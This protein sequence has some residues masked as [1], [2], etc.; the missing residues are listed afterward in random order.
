M[1]RCP[2]HPTHPTSKSKRGSETERQTEL[3]VRTIVL[4]VQ[5]YRLYSCRER[6]CKKCSHKALR[7]GRRWRMGGVDFLVFTL[8]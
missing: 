3:P 1:G 7:D 6:E 5:L 8:L 4:H 2:C